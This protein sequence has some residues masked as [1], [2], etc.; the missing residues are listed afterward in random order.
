MDAIAN[1]EL[2]ADR[3]RAAVAAQ[4]EQVLVDQVEVQK[5]K[6]EASNL[7]KAVLHQETYGDP[8]T[9]EAEGL[10]RRAHEAEAVFLQAASKVK[11]AAQEA[12][13]AQSDEER[14]RAQQA[15]RNAGRRSASRLQMQSHFGQ[16]HHMVHDL[17][18]A[19]QR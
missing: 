16:L 14:Q 5:L 17:M 3:R 6:L 7:C 15:R 12:G 8:S 18:A 1:A 9:P 2:L 13:V 10:R 11:Q 19:V 4:R